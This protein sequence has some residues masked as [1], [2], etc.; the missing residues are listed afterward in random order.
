MTMPTSIPADQIPSNT[1]YR[2]ARHQA[3]HAY[4]DVMD[5]AHRQWEAAI[6]AARDAYDSTEKF[7]WNN[8][9]SELIT[10]ERRHT[11]ATNPPPPLS[12]ARPYIPIP[13]YPTDHRTDQEAH[14]SWEPKFYPATGGNE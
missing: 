3:T 7:A 2:A 1:A 8:Y 14:A 9:Q 13:V 5:R 10:I 6:E 12:P 11:A 4:L